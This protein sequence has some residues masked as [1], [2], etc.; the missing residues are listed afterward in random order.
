MMNKHL[1]V[2][3]I[4][5]ASL[6]LLVSAF[7][8]ARSQGTAL[9]SAFG[10]GVAQAARAHVSAPPNL[11]AAP[12]K[13]VALAQQALQQESP[14]FV[15]KTGLTASDI[16]QTHNIFTFDTGLG[17]FAAGVGV[18][19]TPLAG[20]GY[21]L[22]FAAATSCTQTGPTLTEPLVGIGFDP[23]LDRGGDPFVLISIRH[24]EVA[25]VNYLCAGTTYPANI[26]GDLVWFIAPTPSL[27]VEDC[28]EQ[29]TF[30]DGQTLTRPA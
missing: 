25:S 29:V 17:N 18:Y 2:L 28:T 8:V 10:V 21:C 19:K 14:A 5:S 4:G 16:A 30:H 27:S 22:T 13:S 20:D 12:I 7:L 9:K 11:P 1:K 6:G 3:A 24:P 26:T 15:T 23:Y